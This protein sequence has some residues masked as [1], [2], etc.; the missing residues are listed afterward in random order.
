MQNPDNTGN[1]LVLGTA[2]LGFPYG[3]ANKT[4]QPELETAQAI[5]QAG[6]EGNIR[7]FDTA[8]TYG[9]SEKILGTALKNL[10]VAD[11]ARITSKFHLGKKQALPASLNPV[12]EHSLKRLNIA[13]LHCLM[14]HSED[15]LTPWNSGIGRLMV[16]CQRAGLVDHIGV[17]VY[18]PQKAIEAL[19][20]EEI[21]VVQIPA[22]IL[23]HRF[24][25]A[26][27]FDMAA[28][29][30]KHIYVRSVFLQGL[31]LMD[32]DKLPAALG[33][34]SET[35]QRLDQLSQK[36]VIP[37]L[38]F[39]LGFCKQAYSDARII[40]G[41]ETAQQIKLN[42]AIWEDVLPSWIIS[43]ARRL[44]RHTPEKIINP[45]LWPR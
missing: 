13:S 32:T 34:A 19:E 20:K 43:E 33:F 3:I 40:F 7:E 45:Y 30:S 16:D 29:A 27:V 37:K 5:I 31:L 26:S 1:R 11:R 18:T 39:A 2:Q 25:N 36:A 8:P 42:L 24:F 6:W 15:M 38:S 23:D 4:G 44:F 17:S 22:N 28:K 35:L 9:D 10:G 12:V 14:L 41:A 21:T